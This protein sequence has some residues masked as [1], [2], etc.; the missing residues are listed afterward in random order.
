MLNSTLKIKNS[1]LKIKKMNVLVNSKSYKVADNITLNLLLEEIKISNTKGTA[2]AVNNS[3][4]PK[5]QW[6]KYIIKNN[7]NI[8][9][10]KATQGG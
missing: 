8:L 7:D 1:T 6:E 3:V 9:I 10:I 4:V 5:V 2:I